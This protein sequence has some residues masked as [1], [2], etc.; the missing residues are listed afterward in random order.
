MSRFAPRRAQ[1]VGRQPAQPAGWVATGASV[2]AQPDR[3]AIRVG[4][5]L[6]AG[7]PRIYVTTEAV[8]QAYTMAGVLQVT[9]RDQA[10]AAGIVQL[11]TGRPAAIVCR[12][13]PLSGQ[14]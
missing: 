6:D 11:V 10:I 14:P 8:D 7:A 3:Y 4:V 12:W 2:A 13:R 1:Q 9:Q 5:L